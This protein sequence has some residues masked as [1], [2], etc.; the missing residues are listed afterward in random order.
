MASAMHPT[1][2]TVALTDSGRFS[3]L[4]RRYLGFLD[5]SV[6]LL[7]LL[8]FFVFL[9]LLNRILFPEG[10]RLGDLASLSGSG[11]QTIEQRV[12]S[13]LPATQSMASAH[14]LRNSAR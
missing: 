6:L 14:S 13:A 1:N 8:V 3:T 12:R 10:A 7:S 2:G 11:P 9:L 4:Q 5:V